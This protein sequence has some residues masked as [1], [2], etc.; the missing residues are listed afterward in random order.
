MVSPL[1]AQNTYPWPSS[2][3]V[4]IG[5]TAPAYPLD[6]YSSGSGLGRFFTSYTGN[7][8]LSVGNGTTQMNI[9]IGA[10]TPHPYIYSYS[11][12]FFI[13][14]DG[15]PTF[16]VSGM[17]NGNVGIGTTSPGYKLDVVGTNNIDGIRVNTSNATAIVLDTNR[18]GA[19][20]YA[21]MLNTQA[22]GDFSL[23]QG[24]STGADPT[25]GR[26]RM[27]VNPSGSVSFPASLVGIGTTTPPYNLTVAP[28]GLG[29]GLAVGW[30][31]TG[32]AGETDFYNYGQGGPGG[33]AFWNYNAPGYAYPMTGAVNLMT[34]L[35][36]GN[37]GV[38]TTTPQNKLS[39]AGTVQAYEVLVNTNWSDYVF[40]PG[41][42]LSSLTEVATYIE[43]NH[44]LPGIPSAQ[45]VQAQGVNLGDMQAK[46][47]AKIE[48]LTLHMIQLEQQNQVLQKRIAEIEQRSR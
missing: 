38:G 22:A 10:A 17:S 24:T 34:I 27:Y 32:G 42:R 1:A 4:G 28:Q 19:L 26:V 33:F 18:A 2:G 20:N 25:G 37:V 14:A 41:Y 12:R 47:L 36:S 44:H 35:A 9:G 5:T 16:Y 29:S 3:F 43:Q 46:L 31:K 8:A 40:G 15:S 21:F 39:V 23:L 30:N 48:E 13:G 45:E 7:S 11:N 6:V